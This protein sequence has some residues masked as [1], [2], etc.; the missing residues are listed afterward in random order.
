MPPSEPARR[1]PRC[2]DAEYT[3]PRERRQTLAS[4]SQQVWGMLP[5]RPSHRATRRRPSNSLQE[6]S[7][8]H[9]RSRHTRH[10]GKP[11]WL[12]VS[13]PV[14]ADAPRRRREGPGP[15]PVEEPREVRLRS[16]RRRGPARAGGRCA[17]LRRRPRC[18]TTRRSGGRPPTAWPSSSSPPRRTCSASTSPCRSSSSSG[19]RYYLRPLALAYRGDESFFALAFDRNRARLF[20]GDRSGIRE[21][22]L[23]ESASSFAEATKFDEREESLQYTTHASP[24]STAGGGATI[25]QFHGHGGENVDKD[26]LERFAAGL[27]KAV[28]SQIGAENTT[29]LVLLGVDYQLAAYRGVNTYPALAREQVEGATDELTDRTVHAQGAHRT[30]P[31]LRRRRLRRPRRACARSR[32]ALVS[33]DAAEIVS[34]AASGR[35][36]TLFFDEGC[37]TVRAVRPRAVRGQLGVQRRAALPAGVRRHAKAAD[38]D[39]GWD[40]VDLAARRDG[41]AWRRDPRLRRRGRAGQRRRRGAALLTR[42]RERR[43]YCA[44]SSRRRRQAR[45]T[46]RRRAIGSR[47]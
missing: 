42:E 11:P 47:G 33:T 21:L 37:G 19:S 38:A 31:S 35:V 40:L 41:A 23:D 4:R 45:R 32:S 44:R 1:A 26:E 12:P 28:T 15:H 8:G 3:P 9:H 17:A 25:G 43:S 39:C 5:L 22:P 7:H 16:A 14:L 10:A 24:E 18:S 20:A 2:A 29:P 6:A 13:L 30:R 36:K 34:A 46:C 27:D